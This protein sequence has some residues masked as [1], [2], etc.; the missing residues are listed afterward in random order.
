MLQNISLRLARG[1]GHPEGSNHYGYEIIAPL[2]SSGHLDT[3]TWRQ[4]RDQCR[5]RRIWAGEPDR[6]GRLIH[7]SGGANGATWII[8][9]DD[10][11]TVDDEAGYRLDAH[12]F[13]EGEYVSIRDDDGDLH[14][15]KFTHVGRA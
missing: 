12:R 9:Y 6:H 2:D 1:H 3:E 13:V 7:R 8:D 14:T 5:V 10:T 11:S 4:R 15:F